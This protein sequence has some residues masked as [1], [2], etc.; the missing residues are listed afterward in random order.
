MSDLV[1][2][3]RAIVQDEL[4]SLCLGDL[5]VVTSVFPHQAGDDH[6]YE[7]SVRLREREF[8]LRRVPITTPHVGMVSTPEVGDLVLISY[9]GGD[10]NRP[11]VVGRLYSD[12]K[13]PPEHAAGEWRVESPLAG[14]T[15]LAINRDA[16]IEIKAGDTSITVHRSGNVEVATPA[17][18]TLK[19]DG[20]VDLTCKDCTIKATGNIE[21]GNG[22]AGVIT[23][24]SHKCYYTGAP[25]I[26]SLTVKAKG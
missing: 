16:A 10:A 19:A 11:V 6:N 12:Q 2:I 21:L 22:G 25:L 15:S 13:N 17:D 20:K 3:I 4:K 1:T 7:C 14:E 23:T 26:G 5:G 24:Q 8:E 9:V 18:L